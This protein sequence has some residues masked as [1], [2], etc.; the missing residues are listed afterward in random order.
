M[1]EGF[2]NQKNN[3]NKQHHKIRI[4]AMNLAGDDFKLELGNFNSPEKTKGK[5]T[6]RHSDIRSP[7]L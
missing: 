7:G 2:D 4:P 6:S 5:V 1:T 3:I